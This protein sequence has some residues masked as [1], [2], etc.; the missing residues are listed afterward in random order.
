MKVNIYNNK[1]SKIAEYKKLYIAYGDS[2]EILDFLLKNKINDFYTIV[3]SINK[4]K[5]SNG[6]LFNNVSEMD[7]GILENLL[8]EIKS[9][10]I[11]NRNE[12]INFFSNFLNF[13][14]QYQFYL[15]R[16]FINLINKPKV[17][18]DKE[19]GGTFY[20]R[21]AA[22]EYK[23][24]LRVDGYFIYDNDNYS[25][26]GMVYSSNMF[27]AFTV[28]KEEAVKRFTILLRDI[29]EKFS[30][31]NLYYIYIDAEDNPAKGIEDEL[32][33]NGFVLAPYDDNKKIL[34]YLI[35]DFDESM[36]DYYILYKYNPK[37]TK[38]ILY[39]N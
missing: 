11:S 5:D 13:N 7:Y 3:I 29:I 24:K 15:I 4:N 36:L 14:N 9:A 2:G 6:D 30:D 38:N 20:F 28:E 31:R 8:S 1:N 32:K 34:S 37:F 23:N 25:R 17:F 22:S 18:Y 33:I 35:D 21:S 12:V 27:T 19:Y 10:D 16:D 39:T 26:Q